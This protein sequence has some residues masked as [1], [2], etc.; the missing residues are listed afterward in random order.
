MGLAFSLSSIFS[1]VS[2]CTWSSMLIEC[3]KLFL[4]SGVLCSF[5]FFFFWLVFMNHISPVA[6]VTFWEFIHV[7]SILYVPPCPP[8]PFVKPVCLSINLEWSQRPAYLPSL[9]QCLHLNISILLAVPPAWSPPNSLSTVAQRSSYVTRKRLSC[10]V[11]HA[12]A[13]YVHLFIYFFHTSHPLP[14]I[15]DDRFGMWPCTSAAISPTSFLLRQWMAIVMLIRPCVCVCVNVS[16]LRPCVA[17]HLCGFLPLFQGWHL[18]LSHTQFVPIVIVK[19]FIFSVCLFVRCALPSVRAPTPP[20]RERLV[21]PFTSNR[22]PPLFQ[23][24]SRQNKTQLS[25]K[26]HSRTNVAQTATL[27]EVSSPSSPA[28][29]QSRGISHS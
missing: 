25:S 2:R 3:P 13:T 6:F 4:S 27:V 29:L 19:V 24:P 18:T 28:V 1:F 20:P 5:F 10:R 7:G 16:S 15:K 21:P 22:L 9:C 8:T 17:V 12:W 14:S 26:S 23:L 11:S